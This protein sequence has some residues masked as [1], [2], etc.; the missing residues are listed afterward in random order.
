[1]LIRQIKKYLKKNYETIKYSDK[2]W[3]NEFIKLIGM[4][5]EDIKNYKNKGENRQGIKQSK[6]WDSLKNLLENNKNKE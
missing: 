5:D 2:K 3:E 4:N 6:F 1:M